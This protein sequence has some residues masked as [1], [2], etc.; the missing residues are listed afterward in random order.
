MFVTALGENNFVINSAICLLKNWPISNRI[1]MDSQNRQIA[2]LTFLSPVGNRAMVSNAKENGC[3]KSGKNPPRKPNISIRKRKFPANSLIILPIWL[4][5]AVLPII[6]SKDPK[7][8]APS[9]R[10]IRI[11]F[12][13]FMID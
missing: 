6:Y 3:I 2:P 9:P 12:P 8:R 4:E 1:S 7:K 11:I 13:L 10:A 5:S